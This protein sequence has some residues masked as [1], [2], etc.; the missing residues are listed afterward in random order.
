MPRQ[1]EVSRTGLRER[2]AHSRGPKVALILFLSLEA[3]RACDT[4][5]RRAAQRSWREFA[6]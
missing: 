6:S 2:T 5:G 1:V 3:R 4:L